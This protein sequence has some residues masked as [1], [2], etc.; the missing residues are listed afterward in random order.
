MDKLQFIFVILVIGYSLVWFAA[1]WLRKPMGPVPR[2]HPMPIET[3]TAGERA[4]GESS[5]EVAR[6]RQ[7]SITRAGFVGLVIIGY[8]ALA[9]AFAMASFVL[10]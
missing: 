10:R 9:V 5:F 6:G 8:I 7:F 2:S 4:R 1:Y 3:T